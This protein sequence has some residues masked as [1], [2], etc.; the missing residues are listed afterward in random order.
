MV[1]VV[2]Q[3]GFATPQ[4]F[5]TALVTLGQFEVVDGR[6][7]RVSDGGRTV[8]VTIDSGGK[9][10]QLHEEV[11]HENLPSGRIPRRLGI[12]LKAPVSEARVTL[13]IVPVKP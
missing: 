2:D 7:V 13:R 10:F 1:K 4:T 9:A 3:V 8:E 6:T 11:L 5:G 12:T